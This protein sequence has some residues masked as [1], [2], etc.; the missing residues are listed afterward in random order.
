VAY[1]GQR[2]GLSFLGLFPNHLRRNA[3]ISN[4]AE[5]FCKWDLSR[6]QP[7]LPQKSPE[8]GHQLRLATRQHLIE[9]ADRTVATGEAPQVINDLQST[10]R[11]GK[12]ARL[13][14]G[15]FVPLHCDGDA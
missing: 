14:K 6:S 1:R 3:D 15:V 10:D 5:V 9:L 2:A 11:N 13:V 7:H 8:V 12:L 4:D